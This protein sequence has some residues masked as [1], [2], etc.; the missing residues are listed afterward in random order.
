MGAGHDHSHHTD[1]RVSRMLV[2]AA[3]LTA[4]FFVEL[5]TALMINSIA[6][7]ADAGHM[8]T[9]LVAMFMGLTAVLLARRGST[10]PARTFGW[11]RAEVFTAVANAALLI[12]VAGFILYEAFERLGNAPEVPGVPMIVVALAGL[13]ANAAVVLM[14]R[15]HS[16][17]SLAVKGAYMEVVADTVGSIGVLIA[18]IVTVTT[19]WPYAD[20]VVAVLVAL[21]VLPRAIALARAALRILSESSPAHIDV[22]KLRSALCAVDGV[23]GVHDLHVWTL[24]PGKDMV[25]AHLTSDADTARVLDDARAVLTAHGLEHATVQVEPPDAAGDCR[26]EAE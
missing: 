3:I 25:T 2:A 6:L 8:L 5:I 4:F 22:E 24:V 11:H 13:I 15:S 14:L 10:S 23:T 9:D 20:V 26:C 17:D 16:K 18:G 7:L 19:G 12:G 21:W 1:A